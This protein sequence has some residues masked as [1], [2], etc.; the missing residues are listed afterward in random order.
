MPRLLRTGLVSALLG[1]ALVG[2]AFVAGCP[3]SSSPTTSVAPRTMVMSKLA[4]VTHNCDGTIEG[5][6]LDDHVSM[7]EGTDQVGCW[8]PDQQSADG[9]PGIDNALAPIFELIYQLSGDAVDGLVQMAINDGSLLILVRLEGVDDP[10]DDPDVTVHILKGSGR[11]QLGTNSLIA[12]SQTFGIDTATPTSTGHGRIVNGV[13]ISDPFEA[14]I[15][16]KIFGVSADIR[17]HRGRLRGRVVADES[18]CHF[19]AGTDASVED[20]GMDASVEDAGADASVDDG[21]MDASVDDGGAVDASC[22]AFVAPPPP[23]RST[24]N[25]SRLWLENG[26]VGGEMEVTQI[27]DI[28]NQAG[29]QDSTAAALAKAAPLLLYPAADANYDD[30]QGS[31]THI[32]T[33]LRF[34]SVPAHL[35]GD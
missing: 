21:G 33:A 24:C 19:D 5:F 22:P 29:A 1:S 18:G 28:A 10:F 8:L 34:Q 17:L 14:V 9:T 11:P 16:L 31:C 15:P 23:T 26:Y 20:A 30:N 6:D 2:S 25:T 7:G 32:T 4:L 13:F 35:L 3:S 12:P 27:L